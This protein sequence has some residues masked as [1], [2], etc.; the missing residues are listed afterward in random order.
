MK[1]GVLQKPKSFYETFFRKPGPNSESTHYCP[2]CGHGVVHKL[3]AEAIDDFGIQDRSVLISS[4]GCSVFA[5]YYF[6]CGNVQAAHGRAPAVGTGLKRA[7]P[8]SI[9]ISYQGDGDLAGIG[10]NNIL[11]AANR[12]ENITVIFVNN[13]IYG[14]TGGQMAPT[15]LV[16]QKTTTTPLGRS[17]Q[18]EGYPLRVCELL[19]TLEAPV[20]I[21]RVAVTDA[22][23]VMRVRKAI[24]KAIKNQIEGKGFSFVEVLSPC[25]TGWGMTPS[26]AR[27][28]ISD[29]MME[30]FKLGVYKENAASKE[31]PSHGVEQTVAKTKGEIR[32][33]LGAGQK[34]S[35]HRS[36]RPEVSEAYRDPRI[37]IAGFGGQ[38][39]LSLG[40]LLSESAM[41][42]DYHATWLPSYG[43]EMR[44][45][46]AHCH[47]NISTRRIG[48]PLVSESDV[49][50]AMNL[51][52]LD[53]FEGYVREGGVIFVNSS[54]IQR[55]VQRADVELV[56]VPATEIADELGQTK[57][58]NMVM[59][60][61]YAGYTGLLSTE[62][63][64]AA[65]ERLVKREDF[66]A[67]NE[68]AIRRG[69]E[70][71][72]KGERKVRLS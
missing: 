64:L 36:A 35:T 52:S 2:G 13:A 50:I 57:A 17:V 12:G 67:I 27:N 10:G 31:E 28:W 37:K 23:H 38:G 62:S 9:V 44:G 45:G 20:Y 46:T 3:I 33:L 5:Y 40:R 68:K 24:R 69:I 1:A 59:L 63:V 26:E 4:V 29:V 21:E 6:D 15:T 60:G 43:P 51:P 7:L 72:R 56:R 16:G 49:L 14:M 8:N 65:A 48:S 70:F 30:H 53:K 42:L 66:R 71:V 18:N 22:K 32:D 41:L 54:L 61:A 47:V 25:P 55:E 34:E 58:A 19:S 39:V 11:H